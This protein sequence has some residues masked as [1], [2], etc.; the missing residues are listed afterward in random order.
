MNRKEIKLPT[1]DPELTEIIEDTLSKRQEADR[2]ESELKKQFAEQRK[3]LFAQVGTNGELTYTN[4]PQ[5]IETSKAPVLPFK[6]QQAF[7]SEPNQD[8]ATPEVSNIR[9]KEEIMAKNTNYVF[10]FGYT[11][12][13]KST[14]L[15]AVNMY[16][17]QHYR[18]ILNQGEN[19]KGI[20]LIHQMMRDIEDGQFPQP[21]SIGQITEYDTAFMMDGE[22]VNLTFLEM[23]GEDLKKVDVDTGEEGLPESVRNYLNC[24]GISISFLIVAD[25]ERVVSR[26]E[27]KLILQFLS[28]L[29]NEG[30]DMSR[31]GVILSKFD[32]GRTD[33]NVEEVIR[34][35]LPQVDKWLTSGDIEQP[36]VFPFS[37]GDVDSLV[38]RKDEIKDIDLEDC[39]E[40]VPWVHQV[41]SLPGTQQAG[42]AAN[43]AGNLIG[44]IKGLFNFKK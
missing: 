29:Y 20:R 18:V 38:G 24:E 21:T 30:V 3:E 5:N 41:L 31:V 12:A 16:M 23:A 44:K 10:I 4:E 40:L 28:H 34:T 26:K 6:H 42:H 22:D 7:T 15:T 13:G 11:G 35:Y 36:R 14:V 2:M 32:R 39:A 33:M 19:Q 25:Y 37:I 43:P 9:T 1:H 8:V 27:D 17:R